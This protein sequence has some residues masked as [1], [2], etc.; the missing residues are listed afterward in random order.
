MYNILYFFYFS[1]DR[2]IGSGTIMRCLMTILKAFNYKAL[3]SRSKIH[4][5]VFFR[6]KSDA[7]I[8]IQSLKIQSEFLYAFYLPS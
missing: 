6:S 7:K 8:Y 4:I 2:W 1:V 3:I 5:V